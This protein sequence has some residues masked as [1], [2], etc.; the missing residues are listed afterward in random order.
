MSAR[1]DRTSVWRFVEPDYVSTW[2][3]ETR[4]DL[5]GIRTDRLHDLASCRNYGVHSC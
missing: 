3:A 5:G 2:I 1:E 4:G